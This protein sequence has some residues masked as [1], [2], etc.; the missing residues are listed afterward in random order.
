MSWEERR[1]FLHEYVVILYHAGYSEG[2]RQ[3]IIKQ[4]IARYDGMLRADRDGQYPLYRQWDWKE[5]ERGDN[6]LKK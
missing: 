5:Q 4:S 2:F 1:E 3:D 6:K